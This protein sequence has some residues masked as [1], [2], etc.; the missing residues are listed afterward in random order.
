[1]DD[2]KNGRQMRFSPEEL[3]MLRGAFKGND[4]LL[5]LLRKVFL[6]EIDPYAPLGQVVDLWMT[7]DLRQQTP[8]TAYVNLMARN[9][10]IT[11]VEQQLLQIQV[12]ANMEESVG[13]PKDKEKN[14][15][16]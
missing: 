3:E 12:L 6:P 9:T 13:D 1:M 11:H 10:L 7:I 5:K 4:R 14:S 2:N 8:E 15:V 16:K